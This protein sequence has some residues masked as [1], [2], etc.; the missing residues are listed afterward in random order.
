MRML[1]AGNDLYLLQEPLAAQCGRQ[2]GV[3]DLES[4]LAAVL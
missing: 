2:F 1:Q 4:N 3:Q